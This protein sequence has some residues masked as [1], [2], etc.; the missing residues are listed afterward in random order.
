MCTL[1]QRSSLSVMAS[2]HMP[3][4]GKQRCSRAYNIHDTS[5]DNGRTMIHACTCTTTVHYAIQLCSTRYSVHLGNECMHDVEQRRQSNT[6]T[7]DATNK[8]LALCLYT[9]V[10]CT[11]IHVSGRLAWAREKKSAR[12]QDG[13]CCSNAINCLLYA[14]A[15][16]TAGSPYTW[17]H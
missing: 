1:L 7:S 14:P 3:L 11:Y 13:H 5:A 17:K 15:G 12:R 4:A 9:V 8:T 6:R 10:L 2:A 16:A